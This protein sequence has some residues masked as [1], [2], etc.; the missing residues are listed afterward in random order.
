MES[1]GEFLDK[2]RDERERFQ[3]AQQSGHE[4]RVL[5]AFVKVALKWKLGKK[6]A[7]ARTAELA[8]LQRMGIDLEAAP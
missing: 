4:I 6:D 8:H 7:A 5:R 2:K 1:A 3:S